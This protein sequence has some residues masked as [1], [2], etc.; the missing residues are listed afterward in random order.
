MYIFYQLL[1]QSIVSLLAIGMY[2]LF[3]CKQRVHTGHLALL[4]FFV[5]LPYVIYHLFTPVYDGPVFTHLSSNRSP[6]QT[7]VI[8]NWGDTIAC[9][10][11]TIFE[12]TTVEEVQEIVRTSNKIRVVG[13]GHSFSPL[14]CTNDTI[15]SLHKMNKI[16]NTTND[17]VTCEAGSTLKHL[18][19][20]LLKEGK[21]IH[22]FGSIQ[23]Q[24]LAG[25]FSTSHHG[26]TFHSF[27]EDVVAITAVLSNGTVITTTDLYYWRSHLGLLGI[28]TSMTLQMYPNTQVRVT[29]EKLTLEEALLRLPNADAGIIETNY[30]QRDQG[31]L[32][33]ITVVGKASTE[34]YPNNSDEFTPVMW[35]SLVI[36]TLVLF[37]GLSTFPLLDLQKQTNQY[38]T[39]MVDAWSKFPE[40]GMMY[41]AYAIPF[42]NCSTFM[43]AMKSDNHDISTILIRFV[44]GQRNTTCLT[45]AA[46][47]ACVVDVY[48]LQTQNM[49]AFH[50]YLESLVHEYGGTSHWG[51]YYAGDMNKQVENI[52]C[53]GSFKQYRDE[54]D[55]EWKFVN[56]YTRE[57]I[58]LTRSER[59]RSNQYQS[60]RA[61]F[62]MVVTIST[63]A[64]CG[65]YISA[66][67]DKNDYRLLR[68]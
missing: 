31:L 13:G 38:E 29:E 16:L 41:S 27:A 67:F 44:R 25:A 10:P 51:K 59:Y 4:L 37:P 46:E 3:R 34:K 14:V 60:K 49:H 55:P 21:I 12:P 58:D 33:S 9:T 19:I 66:C 61:G 17:T 23:D 65:V 39:P 57:I 36:P 32:K 62:I 24:T 1:L 54:I 18:L 20:R 11:Q 2:L 42:H 35:D 26:W 5:N 52:P 63:L 22:G 40:Y 68:S 8:R 48:D 50:V 47:D 43:Q 15:V 53:Y 30:N 45:F 64:I 6:I 7:N 28:I 56:N